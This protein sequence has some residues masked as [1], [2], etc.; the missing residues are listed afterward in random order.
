MGRIVA[1]GEKPVLKELVQIYQA[2]LTE[3]L[4]LK[5]TIKKNINSPISQN[6]PT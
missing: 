3:A 6:K 1:G 4:K 2:A 5:T